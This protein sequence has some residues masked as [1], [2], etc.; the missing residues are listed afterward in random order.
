M[1]LTKITLR[2]VGVHGGEQSFDFNTSPQKP[3]VLYGGTNGAGKTT[4]FESIKICL[5][6]QGFADYKL[7][8]KKYHEKIHRMFHK[9]AKT[10]TSARDASIVLEFQYFQNGS[11]NR[12]RMTRT[13]QNN[14]GKIDEFLQVEM[15]SDEKKPYRIIDA[16]RNQLQM[17][18]NQMIPK[19]IA[20]M[21]FFDGEKIQDIVQSGNEDAHIRSSFDTLLGLDIP[22]ILSE[23]IGLYLLRNSNAEADVALL[24]E[25]EQKTKEKQA[26]EQKLTNLHEKHVFLQSEIGRKHRELEQREQKFFNIGGSFAKEHQRLAARKAEIDIRIMESEDLIREMVET[27]LP[28]AIVQDILIQIKAE[29][30]S[31]IAKLKA[32][33][34]RETLEHAFCKVHDSL[35]SELKE[36]SPDVRNDILEKISGITNM[37]LESL[38]KRQS[39]TFDFSLSE[40]RGMQDRID[41]ISNGKLDNLFANHENHMKCLED[42]REVSARLNVAPQQDEAGPLY[43]EIKEITLEIG[44]MKQELQ[45]IENLESQ[46]KS[47]MV[48]QNSKIRSCLAR[49][50][51]GSAQQRGLEMIPQIQDVLE[52][53]SHRLRMQKIRLLESNILEG[54]RKCF[55]KDRLVSG[56]SI[57]PETYGVTMYQEDDHEITKEQLAAGEL[58]MYATAIVW[59]LARTSGRSLPFVI[60][61]PLARL[62]EK[63]RENLIRNFYPTASHQTIIFST[64]T[65]IIGPYFEMLKPYI[66]H[67]RLIQYDA[68][69]DGSLVSD[70]YFEGGR[71]IAS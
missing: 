45:R 44:E 42:Q 47:L 59:G 32:G 17:V 54:I 36:Y 4:L 1:L 23:D 33:F 62:D 8:K 10:R 64:N 13:W 21:F 70:G 7:S 38:P 63:H 16:E 60:D 24:A 66:S 26:S 12:Y 61:T 40:M 71:M 69:V 57:D 49:K 31:D 22:R 30:N 28:L 37:Q 27:T 6:G 68:K 50:K 11:K 43:S 9:N 65:E 55:H 58:Q 18:I 56:I 39:P 52:D 34:E 53:Y 5:Y 14:D 41:S 19:A 67:A 48:L 29:L 3:I 35:E 15:S 25:L 2:D 51:A 20:N 46:E